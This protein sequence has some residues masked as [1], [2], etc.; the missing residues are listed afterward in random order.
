MKALLVLL[1]LLTSFSVTF[2]QDA[3]PGSVGMDPPDPFY[4]TLGNGGYDAQHYH[5]VL[6]VDLAESHLENRL[7]LDA[8]ATQ[9]LSRFNLDFLGFEIHSLTVNDVPAE[10]ERTFGELTVIPAAPLAEGEAFQ[11]MVHYSGTPEDMTKYESLGTGWNFYLGGVYVVSEP[12][13]SAQWFPVNDH[14]RD[15]ATYSFS[16]TVPEPYVVAA[17]GLLQGVDE[18]ADGTRTYHWVSE[19]LM[20]SYLVTV[21]IAEFALEE[22]EGPNG[23]PIR[24]YFPARLADRAS[25]SFARTADMVAFFS[26]VFG[27]YPFEAYGV[28]VTD[29]P[30]FFALETQTLS[31]FGL[32]SIPGTITYA[33][34]GGADAVENIVAH[35]LA[36]QWFGN[37]VTP[38]NWEDIWLNEGFA[39]YA[40]GLW[41]EHD[42]GPEALEAYM[43][44]QYLSIRNQGYTPGSPQPNNL[45]GNGIYPQGAWTLHA[46]R[47]EIGE[48]AFFTLL[49]TYAERY[50][51][52]NISTAEFI[53]L[54]EEVSGQD[55]TEFFDVWLY[56]GELPSLEAFGIPD[57]T[58]VAAEG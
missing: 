17:N 45:F 39:T 37:S 24:N 32:E 16:V 26:D 30:L 23:L 36:H 47:H 4:T 21:N 25:E 20:A 46:L 13:G 35:E 33:L 18:H 51:Y 40:S 41:F 29:T 57:E 1:L 9:P 54:A 28:V 11:V 43:H 56:S 49:P 7:T 55:L 19:H 5:M 10:Y 34:M 38:A 8:I 12:S 6:N 48:E 14:P 44:D 3:L 53:A 22:Q 58:P 42:R 27:P 31:V 50:Q 2:A 52:S 15:K